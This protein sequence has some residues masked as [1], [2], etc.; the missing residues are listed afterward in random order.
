[1]R[2]IVGSLTRC[3][4][5]GC[6]YTSGN[7]SDALL[8][9]A[10]KVDDHVAAEDRIELLRNAI[11]GIHEVQAAKLDA[12]SQFRH[13]PNPIGAGIAAAHEVLA[14]QQRLHGS[15][16][17]VGIDAL[18]GF[19]QDGGGDVAGQ[20]PEAE[21]G[22]RQRVL[23]EHNGHRVRLFAARTAR[24]PDLEP[25]SGVAPGQLRQGPASQKIEVRRLAEKIGLVGRH[26]VDQMRDFMLQSVVRE[27]IFAVLA[28]G[29]HVEGLQAALDAHLEHGLLFRA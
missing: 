29:F 21:T 3:D 25:P 22:M 7:C 18:F 6:T 9:W 5:P 4:S 2:S 11:I 12:L 27:E 20:N 8:R 24:A 10:V 19:F 26:H 17:L 15:H 23:A 1:M 16:N 14:P 28:V 13:H